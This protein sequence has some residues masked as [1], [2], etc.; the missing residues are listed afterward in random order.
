MQGAELSRYAVVIAFANP[1]KSPAAIHIVHGQL[2]GGRDE[3]HHGRGLAVDIR[4][5]KC[6]GGP[7]SC[8]RLYRRIAVMPGEIRHLEDKEA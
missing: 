4:D 6:R 1:L 3:M 2:A 7:E 8:I 5:A